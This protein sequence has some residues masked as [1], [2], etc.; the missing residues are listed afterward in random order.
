MCTQTPTHRDKK[1][2]E[3]QGEAASEMASKHGHTHRESVNQTDAHKHAIIARGERVTPVEHTASE[4]T[5]GPLCAELGCLPHEAQ[6]SG[7]RERDGRRWR[8]GGKRGGADGSAIWWMEEKRGRWKEEEGCIGERETWRDVRWGGEFI[9]N[10]H[11]CVNGVGVSVLCLH[12]AFNVCSKAGQPRLRCQRTVH[13]V[14]LAG[15]WEHLCHT[16]PASWSPEIHVLSC[17][18]N[19]CVIQYLLILLLNLAATLNH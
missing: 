5:E 14:T 18:N 8:V 2:H 12:G 10:I 13:W 15:R 1:T 4:G 3:F 7:G 11:V 19:V 16:Q 9:R 17:I 6:S